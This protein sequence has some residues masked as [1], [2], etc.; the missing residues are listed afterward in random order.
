MHE[1]EVKVALR[2]VDAVMRAIEA[3][4]CTWGEYIHQDDTVYVRD[5]SSP[6]AYLR[7]NDFLRLRVQN[8]DKVI[9]TLKHHPE[10]ADDPD[11]APLEQ[12]LTVESREGMEKVLNTLGFSEAVRLQKKR[13]KTNYKKWE[14]CVDEVEGLGAFIELEELAGPEVSVPE[15]RKAMRAFLHSVGIADTEQFAQRYDT[16]LLEK[17]FGL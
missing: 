7:N 10:R 1:I 9:F 2:D 4:G 12:E 17:K 8:N 11:S 3:L 5:V 16:L 13:R 15:V 14:I 6:E